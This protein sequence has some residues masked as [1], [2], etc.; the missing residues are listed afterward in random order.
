MREF[1]KTGW[2]A[3]LS[4]AIRKYVDVRI[5]GFKGGIR[6]AVSEVQIA[7]NAA[8]IRDAIVR[9]CLRSAGVNDDIEV[10]ATSDVPVGS[11]LGGSSSFAVGLLNCL[12]TLKHKPASPGKLAEEACRIEIDVLRNPIGKQ[13][14]YIAA[15]GGL[16]A[17]RFNADESVELSDV[18]ISEKNKRKLEDNLIQVYTGLTHTAANVLNEQR[19]NAQTKL[20]IMLKMRQQV[21]E[22]KTA[23]EGGDLDGFGKM[24]ST[25]WELKKQLAGGI[26]NPFIDEIYA[27]GLETGALGGKLSGAGAGGYLLFYCPKSSQ[28]RLKKTFDNFELSAVRLESVGS[29]IE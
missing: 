6:V 10:V 21:H 29:M 28:E 16:R 19:S 1:Y 9:E 27:K 18:R 7:R 23:L 20:D 15:F 8:D 26:S 3:V 24:L 22:G 25:N 4:T 12:Y 5:N 2:T 11:G 17:I 13:D 14:Q